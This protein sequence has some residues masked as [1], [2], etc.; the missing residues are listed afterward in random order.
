[1]SEGI[2]YSDL[3]GDLFITEEGE[4]VLRMNKEQSEQ[5]CGSVGMSDVYERICKHLESLSGKSEE[6]D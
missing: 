5:F 2:L 6:N 4:K 1:M 3:D